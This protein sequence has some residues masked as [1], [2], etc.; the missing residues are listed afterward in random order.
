MGDNWGKRSKCPRA[1]GKSGQ[2]ETCCVAG[3]KRVPSP[4][5]PTCLLPWHLPPAPGGNQVMAQADFSRPSTRRF[6]SADPPRDSPSLPQNTQLPS[7]RSSYASS[8]FHRCKDTGFVQNPQSY[9]CKDTGFCPTVRNPQSYGSYVSHVATAI[10][11]GRVPQSQSRQDPTLR[12]LRRKGN[13]GLGPNS[14]HIK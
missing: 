4:P 2:K 10:I 14:I 11:A 7:S 8:T 9:G 1:L 5:P 13:G 12:W 3:D 6:R